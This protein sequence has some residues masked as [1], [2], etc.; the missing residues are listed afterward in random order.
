MKAIV[1]GASGY[2]GGELLRIIHKH[3]HLELKAAFAKSKAGQPISQ[4][5]GFL[6]GIF[7]KNFQEIDLSIIKKDDVVFLA[8]PH[9]ESGGLVKEISSEVKIVDLGAD[10]RLQNIQMWDKYYG[11]Q[12]AGSWTYGLPEIKGIR[13]QVAISNR[14][15][16]PGCYATA[17]TVSFAPL[18]AAGL[19]DLD[20]LTVV[21]SSG[22]TGAGKK[23]VQQ[24]S[25]SEVIGS[26]SNYKSGG[27]HQHIPE[28]QQSLS[29]I[30]KSEVK[31]SFNP[32]LAPMTRG[33]IATSISKLTKDISID[34]VNDIYKDYYQREMFI[35][36]TTNDLKTSDVINTNNINLQI[37][38]D[39][40]TKQIS[41]NSVIDNLIKGAS[42]QAIQNMNLMCEWEE[43]EG[44]GL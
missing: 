37:K 40:N 38:I 22:T 43:T 17:I 34:S 44:L 26:M 4:E 33:I 19:I 24:L 32:I 39:D 10:F 12:H 2:A 25:A 27:V 21:A 16:N 42:G 28:I 7:D 8:L 13:E 3:P 9:G 30:S 14:V 36:I 18:L 35:N 6:Q 5:H 29:Q 15:A 11:G 23:A 31:L 41:V 1:V 20:F